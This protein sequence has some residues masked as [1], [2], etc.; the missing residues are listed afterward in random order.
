MSGSGTGDALS[1]YNY[2]ACPVYRIEK[3]EWIAPLNAASDLALQKEPRPEKFG[4]SYHSAKDALLSDESIN[5]FKKYCLSVAT[6]ILDSQ[7]FDL[8]GLKASYNDLWVQEFSE[9]GGGHHT[10][11]I[12]A[13]NHISGFYYL[14][15]TERTSKPVFH[16]PRPAALM[17]NLPSKNRN[18]IDYSTEKVFYNPVPGTLIFFNS[19]L[20]HE[21]SV[22]EGLDP[23][24]FVHFNIQMTKH[25]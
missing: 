11:H 18:Q 21:Y 19:Y 24:R 22:D 12:H 16:D 15:C 17:S 8:F 14:K 3:P 4:A 9:L 10:A 7:G 1:V 20:T 13:N 2:F 5:P 6:E 25:G 23:F